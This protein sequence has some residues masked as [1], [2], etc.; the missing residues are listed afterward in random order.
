[1]LTS[2]EK[3][4]DETGMFFFLFMEKQEKENANRE[5][6]QKGHA[7]LKTSV[8]PLPL[9]LTTSGIMLLSLIL[10]F[11]CTYLLFCSSFFKSVC[12]CV[13]LC[14]STCACLLVRVKHCFK[15]SSYWNGKEWR[16]A[17]AEEQ[18]S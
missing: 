3:S 18:A 14:V 10:C 15:L 2:A 9:F 8:L 1:M 4:C 6:R 13:C 11:L 5:E 16:K 7:T 12:V 17:G